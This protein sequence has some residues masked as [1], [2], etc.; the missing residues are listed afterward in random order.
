MKPFTTTLILV[1]VLFWIC[2]DTF[3]QQEPS[4]C[5]NADFESGSLSGWTGSTGYC[6]AIN[7]P[8][9]GIVSGQHTIMSGSGTD[10]YACIPITVVAPG[11]NFSV[12]LGN[13]GTGSQAER[14]R[15]IFDVTPESTLII[16]KYAVVLEDP[17]HDTYSQPRFEAQ[18]LDPAGVPIPCTFYQ[19]SSS[20]N[21][22]GFQNCGSIVCK[23]WTTVGIDVSAYLGQSVTLDIATGDCAYGGHYGYAYVDAS[24]GPLEIDARYCV[25]N[26][27]SFLSAPEGFSYLW[28]NGATTQTTTVTNAQDGQIVT[29]TLTSVT[30]CQATLSTVLAPSSTTA[31]F[32]PIK[33]CTGLTELAN[34]SVIQN[35]IIESSHWISSDGFVSDSLDFF[36]QYAQP[37]IYDIRLIV[38]SDAQC[39]DTIDHQIEVYYS[40][41]AD[42]N[43][44]NRCFDGLPELFT[45]NSTI[46]DNSPFTN[47]W[48]I[49]TLGINAPGNTFTYNFL[50]PDTFTVELLVVADNS[51]RDSLKTDLILYPTP[52]ADFSFVEVCEGLPVVFTDLSTFATTT[53]V[54]N[55]QVPSQGLSS[56]EASPSLQ[57]TT[58]GNS[59]VTLAI[60]DNFGTVS[61]SHDVTKNVFLHAIPDIGWTGDTTLCKGTDLLIDN[62]TIL[63]TEEDIAYQWSYN[64]V[65]IS[66]STDLNYL[67]QDT[68]HYTVHLAAQTPFGCFAETSFLNSVYP[69]PVIDFGPLDTASCVPMTYTPYIDVTNYFGSISQYTWSFGDGQS[70]LVSNPSY[71]YEIADTYNIS[72]YVSA[73]DNLQQCVGTSETELFLHSV[74]QIDWSGDTTQCFGTPIEITNLT[75]LSNDENI[76]YTWYFDGSPVTNAIDLILPV[77]ETGQYIVELTAVTDF[78]C[79]DDTSFFDIVYPI[80]EIEFGPL[81]TAA[82]VPMVYAPHI[83]VTNY[84]GDISHYEWNFDNGETSEISNPSIIY[85]IADEYNIVIAVTAG[86]DLQQCTG[87]SSTIAFMHSVPQIDWAGDT[88]LCFGN[89]LTITN[90]TSLSNDEHISYEWL[91]DSV[92]VLQDTHLN[93]LPA[94]TGQF[95]VELTAITD[96]GC[97]DD[98]SFT[99]L[100]Y[101]VPTVELLPADTAACVPLLYEPSL[102]VGNYWGA[103]SQYQWNFGNGEF[104]GEDFPATVF[105]SAGFYT[106]YATVT[107]GNTLQQCTGNVHGNVIAWPL[108]VS[109]FSWQPGLVLETDP[110]VQFTEMAEGEVVYN[111][112]I[113]GLQFSSEANPFHTFPYYK[114]VLYQ[115]C[116]E[117]A[118]IHGCLDSICYPLKVSDLMQLHVPNAFTPNN[119]GLNDVFIPVIDNVHLL[120]S[121]RFCIF[122]RWGVMIFE[123]ED[124]EKPWTGDM[125]SGGTNYAPDGAYT[126][127]LTYSSERNQEV[128]EVVGKVILLR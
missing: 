38:K 75:S 17:G 4:A 89:L 41:V 44:T 117:V 128:K 125:V 28:S 1:L 120:T 50:Q 84:F 100:V 49:D 32:D 26:G 24:C 59:P 47:Y 2:I 65:N 33:T 79:S 10:P 30:G 23:D 51:C 88:T 7:T 63:S 86:D 76:T 114:P 69:V 95:L 68:G 64:G 15:Y 52:V 57:F 70:A 107:A 118:T 83:E 104:S 31:L 18:V 22:P 74:P 77:G 12:R 34:S 39:V 123:T 116:L 11:S 48:H 127:R 72:I 61:C 103:I 43:T 56:A 5:P 115:V 54:Y 82:C 6:C 101:P 122:N 62:T 98:T 112:S 19:V 8:Y 42:F 99:V 53:P 91:Y 96:F 92:S 80:P 36:H 58:A 55:W 124:P 29:C 106:V 45:A 94:D 85:D 81:D 46:P 40:P 119:D 87:T 67:P 25:S 21:I 16:Y 111:W 20:A 14:L 13:S 60:T 90:L 105:D 3:G 27:V 71:V 37:G 126:W 113:A 109:D 66:Q 78:G 9:Q 73:G 110:S 93:Y 108:P 35:G 97:S 121:Y 102:S